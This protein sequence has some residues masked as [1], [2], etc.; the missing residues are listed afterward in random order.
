VV[1]AGGF[2]AGKTTFIHSASE[3]APVTSEAAISVASI[4]VDDLT[5]VPDKNTMT[6]ALD[7]GRITLEPGLVIYAFG[8][9]GV[10]RMWHLWDDFVQGAIGAVVLADTRR[11]ADSFPGIDYFEASG[12]PFIVAINGFDGQFAHRLRAVRDALAISSNVPVIPC[13]ARNRESVKATLVTLI[14]HALSL[15]AS[16]D[17]TQARL[18]SRAVPS[19]PE[20]DDG[21]ALCYRQRP[22]VRSC[23]GGD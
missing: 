20:P 14:E 2:G 19:D 13:D 1:I 4:A 6:A 21:P 22:C 8:V 3:I 9:P 18:A 16:E 5:G 11:L 10:H 23:C 12:L 17:S 7:F 15:S